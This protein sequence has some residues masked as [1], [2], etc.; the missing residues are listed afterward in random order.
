MQ[1]NIA[2]VFDFDDTLAPD[3]TSGFLAECGLDVPRFWQDEVHPLLAD[4]WDPVPAYLYKMIEKSGSGEIEPITRQAL[5]NW[6]SRLPLFPG[7]EDIFECLRGV[8]KE[9]NPK[10]VLEFYLIS[11]GIGDVLRN[12]KI[13]HQFSAIWA[14]DFV[15][16]EAEQI[17]FPKRVVS[18]TDKTRY[19]FHIQK[20]IFGPHF[21]DKPFEVNRKVPQEKIR[22]PIS[23]MIMVG[24]G[25]T[26]IPCFSLVRREQGIAIGV[27]DRKNSDRRGRAWGFIEE[28]RVSNLATQDYR[29]GYGLSDSLIMAVESIARRISLASH[30]YQG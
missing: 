30:T 8:V 24:D 4:N 22:V 6:G 2:V 23:Q 16:D 14:S 10:V 13:A 25:Y 18:F 17:K 15:Y 28:G 7:A 9:I 20:G 21:D 11:S 5:M 29:E 19:I 12:S 26:D 27:Y 3:S 1:E